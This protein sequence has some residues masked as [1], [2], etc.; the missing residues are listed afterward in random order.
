MPTYEA[1]NTQFG[2]CEGRGTTFVTSQ[3]NDCAAYYRE[4]KSPM[5]VALIVYGIMD[6]CTISGQYSHITTGCLFIFRT[7]HRML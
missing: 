6:Y 4:Q 1:C 3:I 5:N 2:I 7:V